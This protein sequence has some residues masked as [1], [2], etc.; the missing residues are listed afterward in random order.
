MTRRAAVAVAALVIG[1]ASCGKRGDGWERVAV[2]GSVTLNGEAIE[3]GTITFTPAHGG[4]GP[5]AGGPIVAGKYALSSQDGP[6]A[7]PH[8]VEIRSVRKTGQMVP[9]PV[10]AESDGPPVENQLVEQYV[11]VVPAEFNSR[12]TLQ[13]DIVPG[14]A[15]LIDFELKSLKQPPRKTPPRR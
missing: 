9:S 2:E 6:I 5:I 3:E 10:I 12:S 7:G 15:N 1:I 13:R 14:E 8:R 11:Q 4:E